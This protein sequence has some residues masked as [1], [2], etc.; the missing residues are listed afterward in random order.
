MTLELRFSV[1]ISF[2]L[3][4]ANDKQ[5]S[6]LITESAFLLIFSCYQGINH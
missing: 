5:K 3:V 4:E 2:L 6:T 1:P